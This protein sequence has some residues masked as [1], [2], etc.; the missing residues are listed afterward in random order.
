VIKK[1]A[2]KIFKY[3]DFITEIQYMS[4]VKAKVIPAIIGATGTISESLEGVPEQHTAESTNI[5]VQNAFYELNNTACSTNCTYRT[6]A[7]PY[8]LETWFV[9]VK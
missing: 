8:N 4:N 3:K 5:K 9:S 1:E 2:G 6:A 7:T